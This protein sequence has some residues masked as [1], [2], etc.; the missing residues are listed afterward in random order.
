MKPITLPIALFIVALLI[1]K[2][3]FGID[4][5]DLFEGFLDFV[6]GILKGPGG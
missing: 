4:I 3:F 6:G 5:E 2:F 1:A